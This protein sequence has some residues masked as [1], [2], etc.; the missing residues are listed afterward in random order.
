M[1]A[2]NTVL[3]RVRVAENRDEPRLVQELAG[4]TGQSEPEI[5]RVLYEHDAVL[6]AAVVARPDERWGEER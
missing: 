6:E 5:E 2:P 3:R 4:V 1:T